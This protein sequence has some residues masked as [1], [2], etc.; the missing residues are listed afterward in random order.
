MRIALSEVHGDI[1]IIK[2]LNKLH[3]Y[4]GNSY[5]LIPKALAKLL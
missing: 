2:K 4:H 5:I 1:F 3:I